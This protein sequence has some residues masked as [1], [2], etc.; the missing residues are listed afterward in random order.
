MLRCNPFAI[1]GQ[2][3]RLVRMGICRDLYAPFPD[4]LLAQNEQNHA[5]SRSSSATFWNATIVGYFAEA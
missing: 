1:F 2:C 5:W 3:R 4:A